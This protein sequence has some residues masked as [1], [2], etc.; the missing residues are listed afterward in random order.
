[1]SEKLHVLLSYNREFIKLQPK[2]LRPELQ[3]SR[4]LACTA[5]DK[6]LVEKLSM[7]TKISLCNEVFLCVA[8]VISNSGISY[9][10]QQL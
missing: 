1:M 7:G 6:V 2:H 4:M 9:Y 10:K 5:P 8:E 3:Q